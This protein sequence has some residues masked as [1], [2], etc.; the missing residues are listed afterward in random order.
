[1]V[2]AARLMLGVFFEQHRLRAV[3]CDTGLADRQRRNMCRGVQESKERFGRCVGRRLWAPSS[4]AAE[5][6]QLAVAMKAYQWCVPDHRAHVGWQFQISTLRHRTPSPCRRYA[7]RPLGTQCT[8]RNSTIDSWEACAAATTC[9]PRLLRAALSCDPTSHG[10]VMALRNDGSL[11]AEPLTRRECGPL[12]NVPPSAR[13]AGQVRLLLLV[14]GQRQPPRAA[15]RMPRAAP[16]VAPSG[17]HAGGDEGLR[18][19]RLCVRRHRSRVEPTCPGRHRWRP[20]R[21]VARLLAA[22][23]RQRHERAVRG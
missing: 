8:P 5:T 14:D 12:A 13:L 20:C 16:A 2:G 10:H 11:S 3:Q 15:A 1:M 9:V 7:V 22:L 19:V 6:R 23:P 21:P 17:S 4:C 18:P